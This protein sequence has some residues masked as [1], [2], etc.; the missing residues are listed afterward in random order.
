VTRRAHL[1]LW[2]VLTL[3]ACEP[4]T[5]KPSDPVWGK[6]P[7][8]HCAML[9]TEKR[10]AAQLTTA[11]GRRLH[12]DDVGCMLGYLADRKPSVH[13]SWVMDGDTGTWLGARV[14]LYRSGER[15]PMDFGFVASSREGTSYDL[16]ERAVA[17]RLSQGD[18]AHVQ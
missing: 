10:F 1:G 6:E 13:G 18:P 4:S 17:A 2:L 9:V 15:T 7:C 8:A 12:F 11:D 5:D 16:M 3:A 14:A